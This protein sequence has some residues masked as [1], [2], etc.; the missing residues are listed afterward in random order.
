MDLKTIL[1]LFTIYGLNVSRA[2]VVKSENTN[3]EPQR[4]ER[5]HWTINEVLRTDS[6][7]R[8]FNGTWISGKFVATRFSRFLF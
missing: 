4:S 7:V 1:L 6:G 3:F 8:K 5:K 2:A